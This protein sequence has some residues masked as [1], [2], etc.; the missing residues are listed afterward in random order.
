MMVEEGQGFS[1]VLGEGMSTL[2]SLTYFAVFKSGPLTVTVYTKKKK[3]IGLHNCSELG[4]QDKVSAFLT[5]FIAL[6]IFVSCIPQLPLH[7]TG[8]HISTGKETLPV[9]VL[10]E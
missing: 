5:H 1:P 6:N 9:L 7:G 2:T 10:E 8:C 3:E 4:T